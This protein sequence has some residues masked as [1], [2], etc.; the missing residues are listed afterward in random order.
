MKKIAVFFDQPNFNDYPFNSGDYQKAYEELAAVIASKGGELIITRGEGSYLGEM[1]FKGG[2]R[3]QTG[4][5]KHFEK[6]WEA[7]VIYDKRGE[8]S[9]VPQFRR[10]ANAR[11]LNPNPIVEICDDKFKTFHL[12]REFCPQVFLVLDEKQLLEALSKLQGKTKVMKPISESGGKGVII[13]S[14]AKI[15]AAKKNFPV[16]IQEFIDTSAGTPGK[17]TAESTHDFRMFIVNGEIVNATLRIPKE[18]SLL[19]GVLKS[20]LEGIPLANIP[21]N[22]RKLAKQVDAKFASYPRAYSID[23]GFENGKPKIIELNSQPGLHSSEFGNGF[24][25]FQNKLADALLNFS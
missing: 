25:N 13:G 11:I 1:R 16:L 5:F 17:L 18:G 9:L 12:F 7:S 8:S 22:A 10:E 15:L 24:T 20:H 3:W 14:D 21:A 23:V 2:W 19:A 4:K 6:V